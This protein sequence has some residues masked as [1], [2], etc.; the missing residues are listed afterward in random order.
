MC[1]ALPRAKPIPCAAVPL[2]ASDITS[3]AAAR[4]PRRPLMVAIMVATSANPCEQ[5]RTAT[6][7]NRWYRLDY[8]GWRTAANT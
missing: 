5:R 7:Q 3:E 2:V 8:E 1:S 6:G 4:R